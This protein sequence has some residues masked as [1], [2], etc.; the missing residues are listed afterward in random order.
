VTSGANGAG[1]QLYL[2]RPERVRLH[3]FSLFEKAPTVD[4]SFPKGVLCLAGA[5]GLGKS[6]FVSAINYGITGVV[7]EPGREFR[8]VADYYAKVRPYSSSFF[9]GR[10]SDVDAEAAQVE[11]TMRVGVRRYRLVRGMFDPLALRELE[12]VSELDGESTV[13][14]AEDASLDPAERHALYAKTLTE[15]CGLES[16]AQLAFLQH[17]VLTFDERRELLFWGRRT[18]PAALFIAFGLDPAKAKRADKL[19]ETVRGTDSLARNYSW[20]ASDWKRQL[21][22]LEETADEVVAE[23]E[24]VDR[25]H[26]E[27]QDEQ[28]EAAAE[29]ERLAGEL[30]DAQTRVA[31]RSAQLRADR[32]VYDQLW[33][34]RL[35]GH[36]HPASHPV[37]T[38]TLGERRCALCGTEGEAAMLRVQVPL[39]TGHCPLCQTQLGD[40]PS[41]AGDDLA[42]LKRVDELI[43]AHQEAIAATERAVDQLR[44]NLARAR[45]RL[46]QAAQALSDFE[47]GNELALLRGRG[48]LN[49]VAE[50]YRAAIAD[51][52]QRKEVQLQRRNQ[53][54]AELRS[55]QRDLVGAYAAAEERFVPAF[56]GLA[57][58]FLGLELDVELE[59]RRNEVGLL[60]SV[61]GTRRRA[62]DALS[63]S[64]R[65]FLDIALRMA[66][67]GQ[68]ARGGEGVFYV[69]TPEGSLDIA[70]EARAGDM[71]GRF[72]RDNHRLVMTANINTSQLLQR[73]AERTGHQLMVL[74]R[75]TDWT[76][77]SEVQADEEKLFDDAFT[78]I[79]RALE[80]A[81]ELKR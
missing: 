39:E 54:R 34:R 70:Y 55:L 17:F 8:G 67:V 31:E 60:L 29:A 50:R 25:R 33:A 4:V 5:N 53:A 41:G 3:R 38:T 81:H 74:E 75:M 45:E 1:R 73:L 62:E 11:L 40:I 21:D 28:D 80:R 72:V 18:L 77:L 26:R 79:T 64:Q 56:T 36:G 48:E 15:D 14:L 68:M 23:D 44:T 58:Q 52:L 13:V 20:Q 42:E 57:E 66:L 16:F 61:Q 30:S 19:Q 47:R 76:V 63:E 65:F 78:E 35:Q 59:A 32:S 69:D 71:F 51:Q 12:V 7:P 22:N 27:L 43:L 10:I 46:D 37:V 49:A 9:R 6:T 24:G 2:P